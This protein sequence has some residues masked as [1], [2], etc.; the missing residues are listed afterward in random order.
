MV[1]IHI[2]PL[3]SCKKPR[4]K[5]WDSPSFTVKFLKTIGGDCAL[6]WFAQ[7]NNG[8]SSSILLS[9]LETEKGFITKKR[10]SISN[11]IWKAILS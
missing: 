7:K 6:M 4:T 3:E 10:M 11:N 1:A 8:R 5:L 2:K 9:H